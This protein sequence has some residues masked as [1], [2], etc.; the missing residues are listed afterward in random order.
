MFQGI[1]EADLPGALEALLFVTDQPVSAVTLAEMLEC[2]VSLA[3]SAL[4]ALQE[5]LASGN[6]GIQL[7]GGGRRLAAVHPPRLP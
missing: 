4:L 2:D 5:Q 1:T 6:R 7:P 3:E